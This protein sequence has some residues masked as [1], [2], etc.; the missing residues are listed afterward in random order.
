MA[1]L[2]IISVKAFGQTPSTDYLFPGKR[3]LQLT[4]GTGV[5]YV[6]IVEVAYGFSDRFALGVIVG[7]TPNVTGY[8]IRLRATLVEKANDFRI[9]FRM[10]I[11]YYGS[12]KK[13]GD[14]PWILSWPVVAT[15]WSLTSKAK[16]SIGVGIVEAHCIDALMEGE[17]HH[18]NPEMGFDGGFWNTVHAGMAW[19]LSRGFALQSEASLVMEGLKV[20]GNEYVGGPPFILV[21]SLTKQLRKKEPK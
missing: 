5:P 12:T 9:Y 6:G 10:P 15:E 14:E 1:V 17:D 8:G 4:V 16:L 21:L 3:Q 18:E 2:F 20:A 7:Q 19:N 11:F 13:F